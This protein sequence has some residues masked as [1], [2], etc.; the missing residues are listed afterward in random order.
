METKERYVRYGDKREVWRDKREVCE[1][2]METKER[3][4]RYGD[5]REVCE[6]WRQDNRR[7]VKTLPV[8]C[9]ILR[10]ISCGFPTQ[11]YTK[12]QFSAYLEKI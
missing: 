1:V 5:K 11:N 2:C 12:C 4:V 8:A 6:V 7:S 3:Y 9:V 10:N